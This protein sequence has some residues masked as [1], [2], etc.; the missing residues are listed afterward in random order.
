MRLQLTL[1]QEQNQ[2]FFTCSC[3]YSTKNVE[4]IV[5]EKKTHQSTRHHLTQFQKQPVHSTLLASRYPLSSRIPV[6][7]YMLI[8]PYMHFNP[9][10]FNHSH[11]LCTTQVHQNL[12][13]RRT[14]YFLRFTRTRISRVRIPESLD[15]KSFP[16]WCKYSIHV[17]H[18][19]H[20]FRRCHY[21]CVSSPV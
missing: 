17:H 8:F 15:H 18:V 6:F 19:C 20:Y 13:T 10:P 1:L 11:H 4:V 7:P 21:Q 9:L 5:G 16:D 14:T 12:P 2:K 3:F